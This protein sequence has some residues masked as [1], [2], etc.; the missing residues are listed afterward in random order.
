MKTFC[1]DYH[2]TEEIGRGR[3]G[4]IRRCVNTETGE[5]LACKIIHK[6]DLRDSLDR[7]CLLNEIATLKYVC[8]HRGIVELRDVHENDECL[9]LFME[10]CTGGDLFDKIVEKKRFEEKE[11]AVVMK[12]LMETIGYCHRKG[13]AHRDLK[14]D[15]I[16]FSSNSFSNDIR[17]ADF[18]QAASFSPGEKMSGIVGTPYYVAAEVLQGKDY[19]EKVDIWSAGVILY[20]ML[21]GI[22][23]FNGDTPQEIFE[24]V[25]RE[26]LRFPNESWLTISHSA[27]DLI[28]QML[29][30]DVLRRLSADQVLGH[31]WIVENCSEVFRR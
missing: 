28:R 24:A 2:L 23:P 5:V 22:P 4:S 6:A 26:R 9:W 27:K 7:E 14:P 16:L 10:L 21:S 18:G 3:F 13:V 1:K 17:I 30:R 8:G 15:N 12:R 20:V 11:A 29:R 19:N 31:P 25:L